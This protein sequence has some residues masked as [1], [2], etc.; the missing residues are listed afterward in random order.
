MASGT[1]T[2]ADHLGNNKYNAFTT[3]RK[4][5]V[6]VTSPVWSVPLAPDADGADRFGFWTSSK[7]CKAKRLAHT[8]NVTV[9]PCDA[10]GRV[11]A[12]SVPVAGTA[13]TATAAELAEI[14]TKVNAKYGFM[15]TLS[16]LANSV[17]G[18]FKGKRPYG[19]IGVVVTLGARQG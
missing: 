12:G 13:A 4:S 3:Y 18:V 16:K 5:G 19:D 6:P 1:A 15:T 10:R 14:R 11:T 9:Q 7:S 2:P 17:A 8:P